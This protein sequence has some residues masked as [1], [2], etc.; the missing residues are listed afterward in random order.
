M[1]LS[2]EDYKSYEFIYTDFDQLM[3]EVVDFDTHIDNFLKE[4]P[5]YDYDS[6]VSLSL[7]SVSTMLPQMYSFCITIWKKNE[8]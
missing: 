5:E 4:N 1:S 8:N 6:C 7:E 2:D 3:I